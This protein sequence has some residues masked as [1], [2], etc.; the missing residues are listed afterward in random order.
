D[1]GYTLGGP[2]GK[3]GGR[4]KLFFFFS[5]EWRPR[6]TGGAVTQFRFPTAAERMGDF[7]QSR[8]NNGALYPYIKDPLLSGA[9]TAASPAACFQDGGVVGRIPTNRLY[10]VGLNILNSYP[11]PNC[12]A[13]CNNY[14]SAA[15]YNYEL[16]RPTE[17]YLNTQ[18]AVRV[19]YQP[20]TKLRF[21]VKYA[22]EIQR[23]Q[24]FAGT[25]PGFNDTR[26]HDPVVRT[27]AI[28]FNYVLNST[29]FIEFNYGNARNAVAGCVNIFSN[30]NT[31]IP[32]STAADKRTIGLGDLPMIFP[33]ATAMDSRYYEY[34]QLTKLNTPMFQDGIIWLPPTFTW[35]S[36]VTTAGG[37]TL[38]PPNNPYPGFLNFNQTQDVS[39]SITKVA[40][41][42]TIKS[43]FY[44]NHS[45]KAQNRGGGGPGA[46]NFGNSTNNPLDTTFGFSNAAVGVFSTY[47][48]LSR[49][50][51]G[52]Y[53]TNNTEGYIQDNWRVTSKLTIDA[54]V[55]LVRQQ[56]QYD[57]L[58]QSSNFLPDRYVRADA[59]AVYAAGC[60]G[61]ANP[62]TGTNRQARNP[63]TGELLGAG[64]SLLI[65]ALVPG[66][67][68]STNGVF[69]A[70]QGIVKTTYKWPLIAPAPR[71]GFAYDVTG[72]QTF[73]IRGGGGL[74]FD[75][76][77]G[78]SIY[79]LVANPPNAYSVTAN[80]GSLLTLGTSG[81]QVRGAPALITYEYEA[82]LPSSTQW[83]GGVQMTLPWSSAL[84]VEYVGQHGFHLGE[85][86]DINQADI[87]AAFLAQNQDPTLGASATP[88]SAAVA[89]DLLRGY[90]GYGSITQFTGRGVNQY[91]AI[92]TSFNRR[93]RSGWSAQLNYTLGLSQTN[94]SPA[95]LEHDANG[96]VV[97]RADQAVADE[98]L[99]QGN[100]LRHVVKANFVWDL[101]D[102]KASTSVLRALAVA[103]NDWQ[104]SG[105]FTGQSGDRYSVG[106]NYQTGSNTNVTGSPTYA[107][108]LTINGDPGSG[109]TSNQYSQF[110]TT[111]FVAPVAGQSVGLES[112][113]NYMIGCPLR[114]WDM[115]LARTVRAGGRRT[116][117][118]R[119]D[120]FNVFDN[121]VFT[122]RNA[123]MNL[124]SP[125]DA[126]VT[127]P[128]YAAD[129]SLVPSRLTPGQA[130]FGA[131]T[132]AAPLRTMQL[133]V[134]FGF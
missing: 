92:Q 81:F 5:Q 121:V 46:I 71:F 109:C 116:V 65:G 40:G 52:S 43:G 119:L 30:C 111:V 55:R 82:D 67:G 50:M 113:Q 29:T 45:R 108:R 10:P 17:K 48:Q 85:N 62:C 63:V 13:S 122:N 72:R 120:A 49:F 126:T 73:V 44:N 51:E 26:M 134:R 16:T 24:T 15:A 91:H 80:N 75:R 42:H 69:L 7:S 32:M 61:S 117:Q 22:G 115:S 112:G 93:F 53:V 18:P 1:W 56:P 36:R 89:T 68:N 128:Q 131:A 33:D 60:V 11:L 83:N 104:L 130:G 79:G 57:A 94:N 78:N 77:N 70:G 58:G 25:L 110:N 90:K 74:F 28:P 97:Y 84:D 19:D 59:P 8:D 6:T 35:G 76:P 23:K 4:N 106:Y 88:G 105:V 87:G 133:Q 38:A 99:K 107:G 98:L 12:P 64:S 14:N 66:T 125:I 127:N 9:C 132:A 86:V 118:I 34:Q 100:L 103:T 2:I 37:T 102:L 3:A 114:I 20:T 54:G 96:N 21:T 41:R 39:V 31:S 47:T 101:P 123:T 124:Q 27:I 95:R 129:G